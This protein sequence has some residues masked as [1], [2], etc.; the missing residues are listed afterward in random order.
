LWGIGVYFAR[1]ARDALIVAGCV[2][3]HYILDVVTHRPDMPLAPGSEV[4][5]GLGLWNQL[6]LAIVVEAAL[7]GVAVFLY[8]RATRS[9]G[10]MGSIGFW[11]LIVFLCGGWLSGIFGP[12]PPDIRA[13]VTGVL[14]LTPIILLWAWG[15]DRARPVRAPEMG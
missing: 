12:P 8:L 1:S 14:I 13:M 6:A 3:S 9:T 7:F 11:A 15:I 2:F 5:W 10:R 4:R